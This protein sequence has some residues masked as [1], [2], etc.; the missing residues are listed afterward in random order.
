MA[1]GSKAAAIREHIEQNPD[2]K[3]SD[4]IKSLKAQR[5]KVSAT[6]VYGIMSKSNGKAPT[7]APEP[8]G[9]QPLLQAKA[10]IVS[11]GGVDKARA[12]IDTLVSL[13]L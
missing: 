4:V 8:A 13:Q 5:I 6:Q 12:M 1:R 10:F 2:A 7:K 9:D 3:A 11:A